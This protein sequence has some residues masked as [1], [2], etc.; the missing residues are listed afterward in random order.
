MKK[1][2]EE[3]ILD[4]VI[5][6]NTEM[7]KMNTRMSDLEHKVDRIS[8]GLSDFKEEMYAFRDETKQEFVYVNMKLDLLG[9][10][11]LVNHEE[12]LVALEATR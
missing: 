3:Q 5:R 8:D 2:R 11:L 7:L 12:R 6:I 1:A 9:E 10:K 4:Y